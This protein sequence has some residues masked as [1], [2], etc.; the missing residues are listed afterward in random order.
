MLSSASSAR[1]PGSV[2]RSLVRIQPA[3]SGPGSA[4]V[5]ARAAALE[6]TR[7]DGRTQPKDQVQPRAIAFGFF[8]TFELRKM[9]EPVSFRLL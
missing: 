5:P 4:A 7:M 8:L 6:Y 1:V 3:R 9:P 2:Q